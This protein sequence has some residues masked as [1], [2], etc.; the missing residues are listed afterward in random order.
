M[1]HLDFDH[2]G[3]H[4]TVH[5]ISHLIPGV[6]LN[7]L[8]L[9]QT[10]L[11]VQTYRKSHRKYRST[12][13]GLNTILS[14][15]YAQNPFGIIF[16]SNLLFPSLLYYTLSPLFKSVPSILC[17]P[18]F[19]MNRE[20]MPFSLLFFDLVVNIAEI[21]VMLPIETIRH[22]LFCQVVNKTPT[23][24]NRVVS[25]QEFETCVHLSP[26]PYTGF[27]DCAYRIMS[28]E[29]GSSIRKGSKKCRRSFGFRGLYRGFRIRLITC[30][31]IACLQAFTILVDVPVEDF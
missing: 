4:V 16:S 6:L 2:V 11:V 7:P 23:H 30:L 25:N 29:G 24:H 3:S 22:R 19:G 10:R 18:V 9:V 15:E 26:I 28:E 8:E 27:M 31:A 14:E 21:V 12:L 17:E 20:E 5:I 1:A 13:H